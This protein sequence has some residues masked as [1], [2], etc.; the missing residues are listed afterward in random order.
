MCEFQ[1]SRRDAFPIP[2]WRYP[3]LEAP[4][5]FQMSLAGQGLRAAYPDPSRLKRRLLGRTIKPTRY[6]AGKG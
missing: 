1:A 5:Y 6:S 3:A 4:G 2:G